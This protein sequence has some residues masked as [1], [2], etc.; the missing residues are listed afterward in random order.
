MLLLT[1]ITIL[2]PI[3]GDFLDALMTEH[4]DK[5]FSIAYNLLRERGKE[6]REDA[7]E[8]TQE[9]FIKVYLHI[10]RFHGITSEDTK[11][12]LTIYTKNTVKDFLKKAEH[13]YEKVPLSYDAEGETQVYDIPD[14]S[15]NPE[16]IIINREKII[17]TS[18]FIDKLPEGQRQVILLKYH[19]GYKNKEIAQVLNI[20]PSNVSSRLERAKE[21]LYKMMQ[22]EQNG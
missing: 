21:A 2:D 18:Y 20:S 10:G 9:T 19:Y 22:E 16:E 1:L 7:E 4:G 3:N 17:D 5:M 12:L 6:S 8:L 14:M 13:R 15:N 11:K